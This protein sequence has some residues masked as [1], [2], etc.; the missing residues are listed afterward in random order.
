ML[1][2]NTED[3]EAEAE[4]NK[5]KEEGLEAEEEAL[6]K[7]EKEL[8]MREVALEQEEHELREEEEELRARE[9]IV[10]QKEEEF[11]MHGRELHEAEAIVQNREEIL[12]AIDHSNEQPEIA[13][14]QEVEYPER[15]VV[16]PWENDADEQ[17]IEKT[18][19]IEYPENGPQ[20]D[21]NHASRPPESTRIKDDAEKKKI[22]DFLAR[23]EEQ[24]EVQKRNIE[25]LNSAK[26]VLA[27]Q[28]YPDDDLREIRGIGP[29][30]ENQL[31]KAGITSYQQIAEFDDE[32]I[33]RVSEQVG[34][35]PRRIMREEWIEQARKL[36]DKG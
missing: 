8:L 6:D 21:D 15:N 26:A 31:K 17:E 29:H 9:V 1:K 2:I 22:N 5:L 14:T 23:I 20:D 11:A 28:N 27:K 10:Q 34:L 13:K 33:K 18:R 36:L 7:E 25:A 24:K 32:D 3:L 4:W 12:D 35:F 30:I 19:R 16:K